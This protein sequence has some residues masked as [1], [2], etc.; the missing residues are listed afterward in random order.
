MGAKNKRQQAEE[1][2]AKGW[3]GVTEKR[4]PT[5]IAKLPRDHGPWFEIGAAWTTSNGGLNVQ[6]FAFPADARR[7]RRQW[8]GLN[9][10]IN[11]L[12]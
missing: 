7:L 1:V 9:S 8:L 11:P 12:R 6:L 4:K 2:A 3:Y 10:S 5:H